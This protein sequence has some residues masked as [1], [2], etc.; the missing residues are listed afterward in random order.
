MFDGRPAPTWRQQVDLE[1]AQS[2]LLDLE[3]L[4]RGIAET[5][6]SFVIKVDGQRTEG[7]NP[8]IFTA[9]ISGTT[10]TTASIRFDDSDLVRAVANAIRAFD[11][12]LGD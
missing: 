9:V 1:Q 10:H 6:A 12:T 3:P 2:A 11:A 5:G 7:A 8:P 4:L